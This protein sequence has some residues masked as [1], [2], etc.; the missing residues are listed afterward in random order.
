MGHPL[1]R[2][3]TVTSS[4]GYF[5]RKDRSS[6]STASG[7]APPARTARPPVGGG[8]GGQV[9]LDGIDIA[10]LPSYQIARRGVGRTFQVSSEFP[11]LPLLENMLAA[12]QGVRGDSLR[13]ALLGKRY[14]R[15]AEENNVRRAAELMDRFGMSAMAN[16]W[17]A[18][19]S[20]GQRRLLEIMRAFMARP[21]LLLPDEP[22]AGVNPSLSRR[23]EDYLLE[24][25]SEGLSMLMVEHEM[26][27]V[28]RLAITSSSWRKAGC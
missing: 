20:G 8:G 27:V 22:M 3:S 14:L 9:L 10:G 16:E 7:P 1:T 4:P 5:S 19:L 24:L 26:S 6:A 15:S 28:E 25:K 2:H 21:R 13:S 17:A 18:T 23:M 12:V 11:K